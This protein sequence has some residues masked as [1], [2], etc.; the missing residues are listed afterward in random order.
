MN[1]KSVCKWGLAFR[2]HLFYGESFLAVWMLKT[3]QLGGFSFK[4]GDRCL[5]RVWQKVNKLVVL[6]TR[7]IFQIGNLFSFAYKAQLVYYVEGALNFPLSNRLIGSLK[8]HI[9]TK[10]ECATNNVIGR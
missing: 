5:G 9:I 1:K 8:C 10:N 4:F 2:T 6:L 7:D 3:W